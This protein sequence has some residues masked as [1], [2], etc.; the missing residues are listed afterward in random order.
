MPNDTLEK[1]FETALARHRDGDLEGAVA[2][3]RA[4]LDDRADYGPALLNMGQALR[5]DLDLLPG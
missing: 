4:L 2:A 3:Y 5:H 1:S